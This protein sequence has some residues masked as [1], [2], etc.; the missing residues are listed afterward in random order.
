MPIARDQQQREDRSR[1]SALSGGL[2][3][4]TDGLLRGRHAV[5]RVQA[6]GIIVATPTGSTAYSLSAGGSMCHP[7]VPSMY[8]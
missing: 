4:R 2:R 3:E 8:I 7:E 6:D 5:T 1:G